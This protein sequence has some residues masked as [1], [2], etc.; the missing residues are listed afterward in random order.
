MR[1]S[2]WREAPRAQGLDA[3]RTG[4]FAQTSALISSHVGLSGRAAR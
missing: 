2:L 1:E 3:Q 4:P